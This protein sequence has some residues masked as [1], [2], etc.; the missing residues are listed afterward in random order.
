MQLC[1]HSNESYNCAPKAHSRWAGVS[2]C[3][4]NIFTDITQTAFVNGPIRMTSSLIPSVVGLAME[5]SYAAMYYN[6]QDAEVVDRQTLIDLGHPQG[7]SIIV[8]DYEPA[9]N[10][11]KRTTKVK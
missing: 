6:A 10:L 8:Y 4:A 3:G 9:G 1:I 2:T 7:P 5:A 11:A